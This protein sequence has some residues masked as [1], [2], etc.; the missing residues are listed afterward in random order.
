MLAG[1]PSTGAAADH[2]H[3]PEK[4]SQPDLQGLGFLCFAKSPS[5]EFERPEHRATLV[6]ERKAARDLKGRDRL[7][8]VAPDIDRL[9]ERWAVAGRSLHPR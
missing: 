6:A 8:A 3:S 7:R 9:L 2:K 5:W 1:G 4:L